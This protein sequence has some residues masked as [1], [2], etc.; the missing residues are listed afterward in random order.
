M[1]IKVLGIAGK[2]ILATELRELT[3]PVGQD[4]RAPF[5]CKRSVKRPV[6]PVHSPTHKPAPGKLVIARS[7]EAEG[8]LEAGRRK[9]GTGDGAAHKKEIGLVLLP[10]DELAACDK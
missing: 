4:E 1:R 5:V 8:A 3:G 7:I 9:R 2:P 10:P 6:R